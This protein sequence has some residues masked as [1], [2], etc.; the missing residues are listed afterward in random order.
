ML[1]WNVQ[2]VLEHQGKGGKLENTIKKMIFDLGFEKEEGVYQPVKP[3]CLKL[4]TMEGDVTRRYS[5]HGNCVK[6]DRLAPTSLAQLESG[7]ASVLLAMR[8]PGPPG[9]CGPAWASA[10]PL[11]H[12]NLP[13]ARISG[14]LRALP[15]WTPRENDMR[16]TVRTATGAGGSWVSAARIKPGKYRTQLRIFCNSRSNKLKVHKAT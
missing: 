1:S 6:A 15:G 14:S 2:N 5:E 11:S 3:G 16:C 9:R 8:E 7:V 10:A 12:R 4:K 13:G